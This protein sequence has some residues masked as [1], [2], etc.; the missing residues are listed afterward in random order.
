VVLSGQLVEPYTG[1]QVTFR[2]A[3]ASKHQIDHIVSVA[4]TA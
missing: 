1:R 4:A 3:A 2:K